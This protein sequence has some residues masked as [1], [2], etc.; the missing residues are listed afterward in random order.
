MKRPILII[1][2]VITIFILL[3]TAVTALFG[4]TSLSGSSNFG[5]GGGGA[6]MEAPAA[7][8]PMPATDLFAAEEAARTLVD[9]D[10]Q[11]AQ[12][13]LVIKNADL[14]IVVKD[15]ETRMKQIAALAV[16]MGG[17]VVSSN[18]YQ[19]YYGPN[20][21]EVPEATSSSRFSQEVIN[22]PPVARAMMIYK[23]FILFITSFLMNYKVILA[24][25]VTRLGKG[26]R[27]TS[28]LPCSGSVPL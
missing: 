11:A 8:A 12:E 23:N 19:S 18:L 2:S 10:Q 15:P 24:P 17:Y 26:K 3:G 28:L 7:E 25:K 20:S 5:Y 13:R 9:G 22:V 21:I 6:P 1:I 14:A 4:A 27:P 16:E